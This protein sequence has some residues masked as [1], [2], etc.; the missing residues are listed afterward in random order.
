MYSCILIKSSWDKTTIYKPEFAGK[1]MLVV[2]LDKI[3]KLNQ[4]KYDVVAYC[5]DDGWYNKDD[6]KVLVK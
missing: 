3:D 1:L 2:N 4:L 5:L 6:V